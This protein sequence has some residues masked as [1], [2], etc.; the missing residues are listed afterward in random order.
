MVIGHPKPVPSAT[1]LEALVNSEVPY[2]RLTNYGM[3]QP[4][5]SFPD[6]PRELLECDASDEGYPENE[7][8]VSFSRRTQYVYM[9]KALPPVPHNVTVDLYPLLTTLSFQP[10]HNLGGNITLNL[11][12]SIIAPQVL[13]LKMYNVLYHL[14]R[15]C[16]PFPLP[17]PNNTRQ[18]ARRFEKLASIL[19]VLTNNQERVGGIRVELRVRHKHLEDAITMVL[20]PNAFT[21]ECY[22]V[23]MQY[24]TISVPI[25]LGKAR[26]IFALARAILTREGVLR[27]HIARLLTLPERMLFGD[28]KLLLG[29]RHAGYHTEIGAFN[30]WWRNDGP[31][32]R[33]VNSGLTKEKGHLTI[34]CRCYK[35]FDIKKFQGDLDRVPWDGIGAIDTDPDSALDTFEKLFNEVVDIHAPL[36]ERRVKSYKQ[37]PWMSQD[38]LS[39]M[40]KRDLLLKKAIFTCGKEQRNTEE[41]SQYRQAR[42]AVVWQINKRKREHY[43]AS[44]EESIDQPRKMWNSINNILKRGK[45]AISP[46]SIKLDGKDIHDSNDIAEAFKH[47]FSTITDKFIPKTRPDGGHFD[48]LKMKIDGGHFDTLKKFIHER[49]PEDAQFKI[50]P[51]SEPFVRNYLRN[52]N[53]KTASGIDNLSARI[54]SYAAPIIAPV[55]TRIINLSITTS[56]VPKRWKCARVTPLFKGGISNEMNCYRPISILPLLSKVLERHV[57]DEFYSFLATFNLLSQQQSGFRKNHS[58]QSLLIKITDYLLNNMDKGKIIGLTMIDFRKAFDLVDHATLL[59]KLAL[60]GLDDNAISWFSSYLTD[61]QFQVSVDNN[62]SSKANVVSGVPQGSILGPLLFILYMNDLPLHLN[63]TEIDLYADDATQYVAGYN[64]QDVEHKLNSDL[65]PVVKWSENNRMVVNTEKTKTMVIGSKFK[66]RGNL[67]LDLYGSRVKTTDNDKLL[68]GPYTAGGQQGQ[69]PP[70][71][72]LNL[73]FLCYYK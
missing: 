21:P 57:F 55:I 49:L 11:V 50:S 25:Y 35:N 32:P 51:I 59:Q 8:D 58:C 42:N 41:W 9:A 40:K 12:D 64:I 60:Y 54:L 66:V 69:L 26:R 68:A 46:T 3:K 72:K 63:D 2:I 37:P 39:A 13:K 20:R 5:Q 33:K 31:Q 38:I 44:I 56:T 14:L 30:N 28:L 36:K 15:A 47:Y 52:L 16:N 7:W 10:F 19:N 17:A 24:Y 6:L 70:P 65:Q 23:T 27:H 22:G 43:R 61:R 18:A 67:N 45:T 34:K 29:Y 73:Q 53:S 71:R 1:F 48:T 4:I 62:V